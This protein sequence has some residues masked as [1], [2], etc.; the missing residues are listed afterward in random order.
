ML[1]CNIILLLNLIHMLKLIIFKIGMEIVFEVQLNN[2]IILKQIIIL[3]KKNHLLFLH[4]KINKNIAFY[5]LFI[6]LFVKN[7][8]FLKNLLRFHEAEFFKEFILKSFFSGKNQYI[9]LNLFQNNKKNNFK[10]I[11]FAIGNLFI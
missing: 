11:V 7:F 2:S 3:S 5:L 4:E 8:I 6:L 10:K 9:F 1:D